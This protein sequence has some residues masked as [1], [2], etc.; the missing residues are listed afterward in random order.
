[1][2]RLIGKSIIAAPKRCVG[3]FLKSMYV[4]ATYIYG[5]RDPDFIDGN[6]ITNVRMCIG[7]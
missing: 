4:T 2:P 7:I 1:M 6:A 3:I 5:M